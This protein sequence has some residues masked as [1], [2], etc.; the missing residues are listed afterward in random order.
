[1]E[2]GGGR[3]AVEELGQQEGD[4]VELSIGRWRYGWDWRENIALTAP[5]RSLEFHRGKSTA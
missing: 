2:E 4:A 3:G 1:V 5:I